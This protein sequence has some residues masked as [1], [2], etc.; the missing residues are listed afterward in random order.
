MGK[1][2]HSDDLKR[3]FTGAGLA[4]LAGLLLGG[5]AQPPLTDGLLAP[6][7]EWAGGGA[8]NYAR[9]PEPGVSAYA[10]QVPDYVVGTNYTQAPLVADR[11]LAY[12]D[13]AE[14]VA[15]DVAEHAQT[16]EA[17]APTRW[18]DEPRAPPLY[19]SQVG[20]AYNPS[21]LP[22]PPEPPVELFDPA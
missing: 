21:D 3:I 2:I 13:R 18:E 15:Y 11:V 9:G 5:A 19:P 20:N 17:T 8:R 16:A 1:L 14:P 22:E 10:A 4:V 6:Q 12:E 7:Q